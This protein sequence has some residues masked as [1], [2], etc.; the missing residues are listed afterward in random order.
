[1]KISSCLILAVLTM[2]IAA[3]AQGTIAFH[4]RWPS[5]KIDAPVYDNDCQTRLN[6]GDY[7]GQ[8]YAGITP[9]VLQ[10]IGAIVQ[11][12]NGYMVG[13]GGSEVPGVEYEGQIVF[14]QLRA[15]EGPFGSTY[16]DAVAA[17]RKYGFSNLVPMPA[18]IP[19]AGPPELPVGLQSFCLI[20]EPPSWALGLFGAAALAVWRWRPSRGNKPPLK[21][22]CNAA[23]AGDWCKAL[24]TPSGELESEMLSEGKS[25]S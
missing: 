8:P 10:P 11:F 19:P 15:W 1:M 6:G 21:N 13:G 12:R 2:S 16:E 25:R 3:W 20:P 18:R 9:D 5:P 4:N 14:A 24:G 7:F 22:V 17:G 23:Q